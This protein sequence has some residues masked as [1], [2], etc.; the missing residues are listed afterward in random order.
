[1]NTYK[2]K[3]WCRIIIIIKYLNIFS[4]KFNLNAAIIKL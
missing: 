1:M 2:G 3:S 4:E